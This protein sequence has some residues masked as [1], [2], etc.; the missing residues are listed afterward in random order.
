[1][2]PYCKDWFVGKAFNARFY[3]FSENLVLAGHLVVN[4]DAFLPV[5]FPQSFY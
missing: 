2:S 5:A 3:C 1:M 4:L